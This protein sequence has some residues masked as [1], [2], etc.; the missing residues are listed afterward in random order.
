MSVPAGLHTGHFRQYEAERRARTRRR[1]LRIGLI[2]RRNYGAVPLG[3]V[4]L[5]NRCSD[6]EGMVTMLSVRVTRYFG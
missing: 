2:W 4:G 5:T 3:V 6:H 1:R